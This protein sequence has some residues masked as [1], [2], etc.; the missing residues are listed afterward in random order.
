MINDLVLL[1]IVWTSTGNYHAQANPLLHGVCMNSSAGT[2]HRASFPLLNPHF[3]MS[4]YIKPYLHESTGASIQKE[5]GSYIHETIFACDY[6]QLHKRATLTCRYTPGCTYSDAN[7]FTHKPWSKAV[8]A[9]HE[10]TKRATLC[11][12]YKA[13][14]SHIIG[15]VLSNWTTLE[16]HP[17]SVHTWIS[18]HSKSFSRLWDMSNEDNNVNDIK[19]IVQNGNKMGKSQHCP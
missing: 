8:T 18:Q 13:R 7:I 19:L 12:F 16:F 14:N 1:N 5:S 11:S 6:R 4:K 15:L 17:I 3:F 2:L 9:A 10:N